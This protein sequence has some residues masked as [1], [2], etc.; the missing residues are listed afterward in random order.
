MLSIGDLSRRTGVKVPTIRYYETVGLLETPD[1]SPGNQRRYPPDALRRLGFIR[2]ARGLGLSLE[3]IRDLIRLSAHP[4]EPCAE[5]DRIARD[6]LR[7]TRHRIARLR[8]LEAELERLV[9]GCDAETVAECGVLRALAEPP[10]G[11]S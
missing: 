2:H 1:R 5:A 11:P 10:A 4:G 7:E 8:R 9:D 3:A 6:Q